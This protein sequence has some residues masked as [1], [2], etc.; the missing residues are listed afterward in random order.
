RLQQ[1]L[2][3]RMDS[4]PRLKAALRH[5]D[6]GPTKPTP[7]AARAVEH[8]AAEWSAKVKEFARAHD[9]DLVGIVRLDPMWVFDG[10]E[11][12]EPWLIMLGVAMEYDRLSTAPEIT[13]G[14]EV[15]ETYNRGTRAAR[16]L[17]N[18]IHLQGHHARAHGG[19]LAGPV[20]LI[21]P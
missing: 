5:G 6:R 4:E 18:W 21:P 17:A 15:L 10:Y 19:P 12:A 3:E 16:Q 11:A 8:T 14:V 7:V 1:A 13:A 9:A 20:N 2:F